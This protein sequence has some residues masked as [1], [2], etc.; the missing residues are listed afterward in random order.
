MP[1]TSP[2]PARARSRSEQDPFVGMGVKKAERAQFTREVGP[3][4][5]SQVL[6]RIVRFEQKQILRHFRV[7]RQSDCEAGLSGT[8]GSRC[9]MMRLERAG[10]LLVKSNRSDARTV[11]SLRRAR[12]GRC[13][14][15]AARDERRHSVRWL[16]RTNRDEPDSQPGEKH[17][18]SPI[19]CGRQHWGRGCRIFSNTSGLARRART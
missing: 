3:S 6:L 1:A 16:L 5:E 9:G 14:G 15:A 8:S 13:R 12:G 4:Q 2:R 7:L 17:G 19:R 11:W 10:P 18:S